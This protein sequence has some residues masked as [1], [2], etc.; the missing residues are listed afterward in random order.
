M[1]LMLAASLAFALVGCASLPVTPTAYNDDAC[2]KNAINSTP[3]QMLAGPP[4]K[5]VPKSQCR[6]VATQWAA[7]KLQNR[8][9]DNARASDGAL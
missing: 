9:N 2:L 5:P 6:P 1:K 4:A 8:Q 3:G 7:D